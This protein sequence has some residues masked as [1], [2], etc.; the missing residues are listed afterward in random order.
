MKYLRF[1]LALVSILAL[2]FGYGH[3]AVAILLIIIILLAKSCISKGGKLFSGL[4]MILFS[5]LLAIH[6][7]SFF[8]ELGQVPSTSMQDSIDK[9]S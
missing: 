8:L 6:L 2:L 9:G 1:F 4:V 3:I 7:K 5:T